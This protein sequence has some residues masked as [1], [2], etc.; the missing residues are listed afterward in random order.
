MKNYE[1]KIERVVDRGD[2]ISQLEEE[3]ERWKYEIAGWKEGDE[4]QKKVIREKD[5]IMGK[6]AGEMEELRQRIRELEIY[7]EKKEKSF[8]WIVEK[9]I[10]KD[11]RMAE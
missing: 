7:I 8:E 2:Y 11:I 4:N 3:I 5:V 9:E 6:M 10:L 1:V